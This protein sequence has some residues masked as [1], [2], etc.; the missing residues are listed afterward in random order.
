MRTSTLPYPLRVA[1]AVVLLG[2]VLLL[3]AGLLA[4]RAVRRAVG[5]ATGVEQQPYG[6]K[7]ERF[8]EARVWE[9]VDGV[10]RATVTRVPDELWVV[11]GLD[12]G[13]GQERA[14]GR[15][16]RRLLLGAPL[17]VGLTEGELRALVAHELA[18]ESTQESRLLA[19]L[20]GGSR[21]AARLVAETEDAG[22]P[23]RLVRACALA[24]D[25]VADE[26]VA[27]QELVADALAAQLAGTEPTASALQK[28]PELERSR[29]YLDDTFLAPGRALGC[30]PVGVLSL[31]EQLRSTAQ[32]PDHP[33]SAPWHPVAAEP[34]PFD[35]HP[36]VPARVAALQ[37]AAQPTPT[38]QGGPAAALLER[39]AELATRFD[40]LLTDGGARRLVSWDDLAAQVAPGV[41]GLD[42]ARGLAA[43]ERLS[44]TRPACLAEVL[45]DG[46][47]RPV[48][49]GLEL[50]GGDVPRDPSDRERAAR[51]AVVGVTRSLVACALVAAGAARW[52]ASLQGHPF[53]VSTGA[54]P[55]DLDGLV[56]EAL[57]SADGMAVFAQ[58][59]RAVG[60]DGRFRLEAASPV[61]TQPAVPAGA[62]VPVTAR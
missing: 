20:H 34:R 17:L 33:L 29:R 1:L 36:P 57:A 26:L 3:E 51:T 6:V 40:A 37:R 50:L 11:P 60:V 55:V 58:R 30:T 14:L 9:L 4:V 38:G 39:P 61:P 10:A 12:A 21:T 46:L 22:W 8:Q 41:V 43:A 47:H 53:G 45:E 24:F 15:G 31:L 62:P 13:V 56:T 59:L 19:W 49:L 25:A 23:G 32:P 44:G 16:P 27:R 2:G 28:V 52:T 54:A 42:A 18:H 35:S 48:A 5:R 7:L